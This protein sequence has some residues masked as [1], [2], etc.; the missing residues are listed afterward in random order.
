MTDD[1]E[2]LVLEHLRHICAKVDRLETHMLDVITRL[3]V[4]ERNTANQQVSIAHNT[5]E[6]DMVKARLDQIEK[7]L[8]LRET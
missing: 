6:I 4:I 5:G 1:T 3:G 8:E 2:N 7:R